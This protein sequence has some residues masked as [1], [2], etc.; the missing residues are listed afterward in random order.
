MTLKYQAL[1]MADGYADRLTTIHNGVDLTYYQ[2]DESLRGEFK[3]KYGLGEDVK[4]ISFIGRFSSD[5]DPLCF[6]DIA[7]SLIRRNPPVPIRFVMAG[8]GKYFEQV[9][10][11]IHHYGSEDRFILTGILDNVRE[12]LADTYLLLIVSK[13]EGIPLVA[14]EA[15]AMNVPVIST[16]VGA[17]DEI[18]SD[19]FNGYL[20]PPK[21]DVRE[22]FTSKV[23]ELLLDDRSYRHLSGNA[24]QPLL[25]EYAL[26]VMSSR[27][28][29]A[30]NALLANGFRREG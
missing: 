7:H 18:V 2:D 17:V 19:G 27:Y 12:L 13:S 6:I 15:L 16:K 4:L 9:T 5:K 22:R 24:R 30:F 20:I 8:D 23:L 3:S 28:Q 26:P 14:T 1:G 21:E 29:Q 11:R 25:E 10:E